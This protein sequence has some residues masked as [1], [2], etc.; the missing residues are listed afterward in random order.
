MAHLAVEAARVADAARRLAAVETATATVALRLRPVFAPRQRQFQQ[1]FLDKSNG[2][3]ILKFSRHQQ[4]SLDWFVFESELCGCLPG[5]CGRTGPGPTSR[6]SR[7]AGPSA[8]S[9]RLPSRATSVAG[10][11]AGCVGP[12]P[13]SATRCCLFAG[14]FK[15]T[16]PFHSTE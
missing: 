1:A 16:E 3:F 4:Q 15:F 6:W 7:P 10:R 11:C 2:L 12:P 5:W 9:R 13:P 8:P 14:C